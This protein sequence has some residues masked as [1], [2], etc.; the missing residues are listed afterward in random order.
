M[1]VAVPSNYVASTY[2][3]IPYIIYFDFDKVNTTEVGETLNRNSLNYIDTVNSLPENITLKDK[4]AILNGRTYYNALNQDLTKIYN[5][6][7]KIFSLV[8]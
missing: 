3:S 7:K 1:S 5:H 2:S 6:S 4:D 8:V